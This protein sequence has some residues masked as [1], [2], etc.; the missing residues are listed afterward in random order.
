MISKKNASLIGLVLVAII[1]GS[2]FTFNKMALYGLTPISLMA[3]RFM[4]AFILM[5]T[6]FRKKFKNIKPRLFIKD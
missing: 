6:I 2:T 5:I 4:I 1:W 3:T